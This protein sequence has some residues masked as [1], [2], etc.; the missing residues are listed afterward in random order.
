[1]SLYIPVP[2]NLLRFIA[3]IPLQ[4]LDKEAAVIKFSE[5]DELA[6]TGDCPADVHEGTA[7]KD[8][9]AVHEESVSSIRNIIDL[10]LEVVVGFVGVDKIFEWSCIEDNAEAV[11]DR[12]DASQ[13]HQQSV[14]TICKSK[15]ID[16][17][18]RLDLFLLFSLPHSIRGVDFIS[19]RE[20]YFF[21]NE[22]LHLINIPSTT[23]PTHI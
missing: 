17:P 12:E 9:D 18:A 2:T 11:G 8:K 19:V 22:L 7:D 10:G 16:K 20:L 13:E 1:M 3:V 15:Q 14:P 21:L 6:L 23:I 4:F 5:F